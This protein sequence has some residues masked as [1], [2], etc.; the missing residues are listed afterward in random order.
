MAL[1]P[2]FVIL[3]TGCEEEASAPTPQVVKKGA[4]GKKPGAKA[5]AAPQKEEA[6]AEKKEIKY[7]YDPSGKRDPFQPS[8]E[9]VV[10]DPGTVLAPG[11]PEGP[12]PTPL[13]LFELTQL[14]L[15]AIMHMPRKSVAMV[16]DPD[17][18]GH[19]IYIG[20]LIGKNR[21]KV[22]RIEE[23]KVFIEEKLRTLK[24]KYKT[25]VHELSLET[26]EGGK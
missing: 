7:I 25:T 2:F 1:L 22:A 23:E 16:E 17:G 15:V 9:Y 5:V 24:G 8:A 21:G 10:E 12:A 3:M 19:S 6:L 13:E 20:T 4:R 14:K 18:R 26:R 11:G